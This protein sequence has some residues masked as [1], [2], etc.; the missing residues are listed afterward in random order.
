MR[1][2]FL[3][4]LLIAGFAQGA[5]SG[6]LP[7]Q[8]TVQIQLDTSRSSVKQ[9]RQFNVLSLWGGNLH[10]ENSLN[11]S[12][13]IQNLM[14]AGQEPVPYYDNPKEMIGNFR[15]G[16]LRGDSVWLAPSKINP[17]IIDTI[18]IAMRIGPP[19]TRFCEYK[20]VQPIPSALFR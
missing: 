13:V 1:I 6:T 14:Y 18:Y 16:G 12:E 11:P 3:G 2:K 9:C 10:V 17:Q 19:P 5:V 4:L 15:F 7:G 20:N 8:L